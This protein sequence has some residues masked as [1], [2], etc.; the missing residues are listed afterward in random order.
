MALVCISWRP[1]LRVGEIEECGVHSGCVAHEGEEM[2][3]S[4]RLRA[5]D[6]TLSSMHSY[7]H[8]FI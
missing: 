5:S 8:G 4:A 6:L 2:K 7:V 3:H 1:H